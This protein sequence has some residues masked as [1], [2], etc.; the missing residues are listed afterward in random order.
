MWEKKN[1]CQ[2]K[3]IIMKIKKEDKY[4]VIDSSIVSLMELIENGSLLGFTGFYW[5]L[6][7]SHHQR[8]SFSKTERIFY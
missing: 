3:K 5:V 7:G 2:I 6:L 8:P 4:D 1:N